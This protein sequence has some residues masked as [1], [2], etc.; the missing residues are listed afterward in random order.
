MS[1]LT[2]ASGKKTAYV[3]TLGEG[4]STQEKLAAKE[5]ATHLKKATGATFAIK[6]ISQKPQQPVIA[7]GPEAA[8]LAGGKVPAGLGDEGVLL[9]TKGE[10]LILTGGRGAPR[11]TLYAVSVFLEN[12][13]GIHW[14]MPGVTRIPQHKECAIAP[15]RQRISPAFSYREVLQWEGWDEAWAMRN[16]TN[17]QWERSDGADGLPEAWGGHRR[18]AYWV[19]SFETILPSEIY[20]N[21][22][23][24]WYSLLDGK[25]APKSQLCLS[26]PEM[27]AEVIRHVME[28]LAADPKV[29]YISISQNDNYSRCQ[30]PSCQA[31]DKKYRPS[32]TLLHFINSIAEAIEKKHPRVKVDTLAYQYTRQPPKGVRPRAN[33]AIRI[34]SF[35]NDLLQPLTHANNAAFRDDLEGWM[36]LTT[37]VT[38]WDYLINYA[39]SLLPFPNWF[40]MG[41]NVQYLASIGLDG[42]FLQANHYSAGGEMSRLRPWV[43]SKLMWDPTLSPEALI[44]EFL[45]AVY[46]RAGAHIL[47][48]MRM[49]HAAAINAGDFP[50]S[51]AMQNSIKRSHARVS[52]KTGCFLDL[53]SP[54]VSPFLM[55][56]HLLAAVRHWDAALAAVDGCTEIR[57]RVELARLPV[58]YA[59]LLR[60]DEVRAYAEKTGQKWLLPTSRMAT[61]RAF[62]KICHA[63]QI[64]KLGETWSKRTPAWLT[65]VCAGKETWAEIP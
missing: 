16:R 41:A 4:A 30:C 38:I 21:T 10:H 58:I 48:Y 52:P 40:T 64:E 46:G 32:G 20:F 28:K 25:R 43:L 35:E 55:P 56:E 31:S 44:E 36:K 33:V 37:N 2:L 59:V 34:C 26:N 42:C 7:I 62:T 54:V 11:G 12:Y 50:G 47:H 5:L 13:L 49:I 29:D 14:Y 27:K 60:W 22:H 23:P 3:I 61:C 1:S 53:N 45:D 63:H 6:T 9:E 19:H 15:M 18:Y 24:E 39:H 57:E 8:V 17:G 51:L 65:R